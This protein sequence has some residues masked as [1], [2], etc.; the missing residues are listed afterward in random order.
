MGKHDTLTHRLSLAHERAVNNGYDP[1]QSTLYS[2]AR[3]ALI[4]LQTSRIPV[5][6]ELIAAFKQGW[7][8]AD[9]NGRQGYR[10]QEGLQEA[11]KNA[12]RDPDYIEVILDGPPEHRS[13]RFVEIENA[14]TGESIK[15]GEWIEKAAGYWA[16]RLPLF[17]HFLDGRDVSSW[18]LE[19]KEAR[20]QLNDINEAIHEAASQLPED[21]EDDVAEIALL[22]QW[23]RESVRLPK[24]HAFLAAAEAERQTHEERGWPVS[25]DFEHGA[26]HLLVLAMNYLANGKPV[27]AGSLI[28]AA[29]FILRNGGK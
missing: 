4:E 3:D 19:A 5:T 29:Q 12:D 28:L 17:S 6:P 21:F 10:V 7:E 23:V 18:R 11:L 22:E 1:E 15:V 8:R 24:G 26:D 13:G 25:H 20:A 16:L 14:V 9:A 2:E 27:K